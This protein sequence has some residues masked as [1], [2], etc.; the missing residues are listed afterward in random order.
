MGNITNDFED[1]HSVAKDNMVIETHLDII[2]LGMMT[3][4]LLATI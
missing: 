4:Y 3:M 1:Y 2:P